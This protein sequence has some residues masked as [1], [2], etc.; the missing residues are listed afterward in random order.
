MKSFIPLLVLVA[1]GIAWWLALEI[2][3]RR[4]LRRFWNRPCMLVRW[5]RRFPDA[6][7]TELQEFLTIFVDAFCFDPKRWSC[8]G[9]EDQVMDVYRAVNPPGSIAD[10]MEL[11]TFGFQLQK[12]YGII[13]PAI[14]RQDITLGELYEHIKGRSG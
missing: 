7:E 11:E 6:S 10:D 13:L 1:I 8:F 5:R 4:N 3:R 9:P 2:R 14:W 12:R